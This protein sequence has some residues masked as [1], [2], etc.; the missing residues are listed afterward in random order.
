MCYDVKISLESQLK[1]AERKGNLAAVEEIKE[2]LVPMTDLPLFHSCGFDHPDVLIY[3]DRSED[4]PEI[5][6]WGLIPSWIEDVAQS[7]SI[8]NKTLNARGETIFDKS[9]F[10]D[11]ALKNH[12]LIYIDGFYEHRHYNNETYPYYIFR[13]DEQPMI[14]AGLYNEWTNPLTKGT[15]NYFSII[16]TKANPL[17]SR[18]HNNPKLKEARMPV[19]LSE[20]F[21]DNWL[22]PKSKNRDS[23]I[24]KEILAPYTENEITAHT[25][26]RL[27]GKNR[28][29]N[30]IQATEPFIYAGLPEIDF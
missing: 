4:F 28:T 26:N 24:M 7:T 9:A 20:Q 8:W 13:K 22:D 30:S 23:D 6:T 27:R 25:V 12:C 2:K 17:M 18:I 11:S 21:A 1:R 19:I 10:K 29:G 3:T 16:T 14:L 5:A 15:H